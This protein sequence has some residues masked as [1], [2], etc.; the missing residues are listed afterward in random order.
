[1]RATASIPAT[2]TVRSDIKMGAYR[3]VIISG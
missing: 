2:S 3:A 1:M